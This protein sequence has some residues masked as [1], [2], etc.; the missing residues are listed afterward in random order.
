MI[1][2]TINKNKINPYHSSEF[3]L[4]L[5]VFIHYNIETYYSLYFEEFL[6]I[7]DNYSTFEEKLINEYKKNANPELAEVLIKEYSSHFIKKLCRQRS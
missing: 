7:N 5:S 3:Y 2:I 1:G 4:S 6:V